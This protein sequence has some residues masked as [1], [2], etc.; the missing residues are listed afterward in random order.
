VKSKLY[1]KS[2]FEPFLTVYLSQNINKIGLM[3]KKDYFRSQKKT[4]TFISSSRYYLW[5]EGMMDILWTIVTFLTC[6]LY[7]V[8]TRTTFLS[9]SNY[10]SSLRHVHKT[11]RVLGLSNEILSEAFSDDNV[12]NGPIRSGRKVSELTSL[13]LRLDESRIRRIDSSSMI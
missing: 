10:V 1:V 11:S 2:I 7:S 12:L 13:N 4:F 9:P 6:L 3:K 5:T 8:F